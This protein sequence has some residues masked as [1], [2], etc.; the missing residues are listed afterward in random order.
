[1]GI[2]SMYHG[3]VQRVIEF[4]KLDS[5]DLLEVKVNHPSVMVYASVTILFLQREEVYSRGTNNYSGVSLNPR[6]LLK[7]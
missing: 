2:G 7:F 5:I 4:I 6:R 3:F 1:M